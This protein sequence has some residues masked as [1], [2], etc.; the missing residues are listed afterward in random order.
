MSYHFKTGTIF[1]AFKKQLRIFFME[2]DEINV[3]QQQS[4]SNISKQGTSKT[5]SYKLR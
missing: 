5:L 3:N 2:K 1:I 4:V